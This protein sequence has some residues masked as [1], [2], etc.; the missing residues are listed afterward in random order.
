RSV[1]VSATLA[2][3]YSLGDA[4][5]WFEGYA[6]ENLP[7]TVR[8]QFLGG[9]QEYQD[10]NR[11]AAF[12]FGMALLI[13]FLVLAAQFESLIQPLIIMLTV[14]LAIAGG[15]F[16]LY[17][18]GS[19]LNIYSQIGLIVLIGLA[20]KNGILIVEFANQLRDQG[21]DV[22]DAALEAADTRFRPIMMTGVSTAA[23]AIP[24]IIASGPGAESRITI[25]LVIFTGVLVATLFTL[26]VIPSTY[27]VLGR[28]TKTPQWASRML[29]E[30][31]IAHGEREGGASG[32][33][34]GGD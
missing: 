26:I 33:A 7:E 34:A 15:L 24:L 9:A 32:K 27:A 28:Y 2:D 16:G 12:A 30:Q 31:A 8:T 1:S 25:G 13:V 21:M 20:A 14:P 4:V 10:A 19:S 11:A 18:A 22:V 23:G 5:E 6:R 3:G 29:E 17:I